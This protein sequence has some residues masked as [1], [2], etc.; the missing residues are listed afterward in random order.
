MSKDLLL[1]CLSHNVPLRK[2]SESACRK[3]CVDPLFYPQS[4]ISTAFILLLLHEFL[5]EN[6]DEC[7]FISQYRFLCVDSDIDIG[8]GIEYG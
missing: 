3:F 4:V 5:I 6:R 1:F 2:K 7:S 8:Y